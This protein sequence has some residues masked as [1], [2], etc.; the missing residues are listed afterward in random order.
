VLAFVFTVAVLNF[1]LGVGVAVVVSRDWQEIRGLLTSWRGPAIKKAGHTASSPHVE[2]EAPT[3]AAAVALPVEATPPLPADE[4]PTIPDSWKELLGS[5][6]IDTE[7]FLQIACHVIRKVEP[8]HRER[9]V[10]NEQVLRH[11]LQINADQAVRSALKE[12][13]AQM[14]AWQLW[15]SGFAD[16]LKVAE[17]REDTAP[18]AARLR[19]AVLNEMQERE[20]LRT[21]VDEVMKEAN[22][23]SMGHEVIQQLMAVFKTSH[24]LRDV[25]D[26]ELAIRL[27]ANDRFARIDAAWR[28]DEV[29]GLPNRLGAESILQTWRRQDPMGKRT[30]S[31]A[32]IELHEMSDLN[33]RF[34]VGQADGI[35]AEFAKSLES[36]LRADRGDLVARVAGPTVFLLLAD[37]DVAG[38]RAAA[39]RIRQTLEASTFQVD[40]EEL[41]LL[42]NCGVCE[43]L[44]DEAVPEILSRLQACV[45]ESKISGGSRTACDDG[46]G[47][48]VFDPVPMQVNGRT[49]EV[50]LA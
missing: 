37:A 33:E 47:P 42:A 14:S 19:T 17:Q 18:S 13:A 16:Q 39:E 7:D 36:Q 22:V 8:G 2:S 23:I 27:T 24:Q 15:A 5:L 50:A 45:A 21:L 35:L 43:I 26:H 10:E 9:L 38:A 41:K 20:T 28:K 30:I 49:I 29:T 34:G 48:V 44:M 46:Q 6:E 31:A 1:A 12:L 25:A 4:T 40:D 11:T 32:L 3:T